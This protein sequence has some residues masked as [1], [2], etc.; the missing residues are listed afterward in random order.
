[1]LINTKQGTPF[2]FSSRQSVSVCAWT[3]STPLMTS[4]A[5][6][7]TGSVRSVSAAKSTCPGVSSSVMCF[8]SM[9]FLLREMTTQSLNFPG[10]KTMLV[11]G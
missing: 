11:P 8:T 2:L 6:S 5:Q 4:T 1:M 9:Y 7:I 3:P 10:P